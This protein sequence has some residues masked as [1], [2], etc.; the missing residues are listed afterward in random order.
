MAYG[1]PLNPISNRS[2]F[3][4]TAGANGSTQASAAGDGLSI[5]RDPALTQGGAYIILTDGDVV[6]S[7]DSVA[8]PMWSNN[9]PNLTFFYTSS[10]QVSSNVQEYYTSVYQQLQQKC[11][12][13]YNL[14]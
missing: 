11:L 6:V 9:D 8:A 10:T 13:K 2:N 3:A 14:I 1:G 12:L 4:S 5:G 7:N